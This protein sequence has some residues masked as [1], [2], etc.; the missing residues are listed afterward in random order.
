MHAIKRTHHNSL[1]ERDLFWSKEAEHVHWETPFEQVL[2]FSNP[3]FAK[4][5][6]G[7]QTNLC[8]NA[9]DRWL[10]SQ[11]DEPALIWVSTEV[12]QEQIYTPRFL[13]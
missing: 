2:D 3:P 7:G 9:V 1:Y 4:W 8:F 10:D 11:A 12:D 13:R 6:V 5:Y